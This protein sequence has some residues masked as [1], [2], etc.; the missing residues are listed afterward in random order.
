MFIL[1]MLVPWLPITL[2]TP[3]I[4]WIINVIKE[5]EIDELLVSLNGLRIAWL[6]ACQWTGLSIQGETVANQPVDPAN[7]NE[8]VKTTKKE[9]DTF[10]SKITHG[11]IK[12]LFWGNN[13]L[14]MIQSLKGG[15][16]PHLPPSLSMVN[17]YTE[18]I[19]RSKWAV[20]VVKNLTT[21]SITIAKGIKVTQVVA[22]NVV[23]PLT[24]TPNTQEKLDE[25]QGIQWTK[26]MVEWR[27]K[28]LLQQ[29]DLSGLNKWSDRNQVATWALLA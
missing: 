7:L 24:L 14:V 15:D 6:L 8:A 13:M 29:L 16:G 10:L 22:V 11:E 28:L 25:I 1:W 26:I 20:M 3:T 27:K 9:V 4:N 17:T 2:G 23:L 5:S 12:N 19:S 21:I 18:V